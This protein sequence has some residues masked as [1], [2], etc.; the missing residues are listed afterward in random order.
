MLDGLLIASRWC[1]L[2]SKL[3]LGDRTLQPLMPMQGVQVSEVDSLDAW[4]TAYWVPALQA[5][6]VAAQALEVSLCACSL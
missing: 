4:L 5:A 3:A 2:S 1:S 6:E